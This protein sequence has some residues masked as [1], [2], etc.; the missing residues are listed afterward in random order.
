MEN[1]FNHLDRSEIHFPE[2]VFVHDID[3]RV[4]QAIALQCIL[5]TEGLAPLEANL[6][7]SFLGRDGSDRFKGVYVEQNDKQQSVDVTVE[8]NVAYGIHIPEKSAEIQERIAHEITQLTGL[9]VGSVHVIF[10]NLFHPKPQEKS[11]EKLLEKTEDKIS[12]SVL[13]EPQETAQ[14]I[15]SSGAPNN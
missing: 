8:V 14:V 13:S 7:D 6:L 15:L 10:K 4:F 2:T 5:R 3:S 1:Q 9:H 11:G 12:L